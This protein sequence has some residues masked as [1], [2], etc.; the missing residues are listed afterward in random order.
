MG[1]VNVTPD[2]FSDGGRYLGTQAA[3]E[4]ALQLAEEGADLL[5]IGGESTRPGAADVD[6]ANEVA[7]V[8]PVIA[9]VRRYSQ[10]AIS[11]DTSK[12]AVMRAAAASGADLINDVR[13]LRE[14]G[15]LDAAVE[16]ALPVVLMHM[17]G[18]PRT[19]QARPHYADVVRDVRGFLEQRA[20]VCENAG[21]AR[22]DIALDPGFGF[23]KTLTHNLTLLKNLRGLADLG[24]PV[25]VGLSRKS[26]IE[27]MIGRGVDERGPAS[28]ALALAAGA[29]G[30]AIVRTHDVAST[31][32]ALQVWGR[33]E[34]G[35]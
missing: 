5:D 32:D 21:I 30:A 33:V 34:A 11:V 22:H 27:K 3:V 9:G 23:G 4:H 29:R 6:A 17:Q 10:V 13:A 16:L 7:R 1:I 15:S 2:S 12:A 28:V 26:M 19:M 24:Y 25:L 31:V 20:R 35:M 14:E 8:E 18:E